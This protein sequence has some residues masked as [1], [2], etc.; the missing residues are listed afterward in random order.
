MRN[1]RL[2][3]RFVAPAAAAEQQRI[4][5]QAQPRAD[6]RNKRKHGFFMVFSLSEQTSRES[7]IRV[8]FRQAGS[9]YAK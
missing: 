7:T 4:A 8:V 5:H 9:G 1:N 6:R 3:G 2:I